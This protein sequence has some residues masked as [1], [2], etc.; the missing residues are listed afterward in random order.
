MSSRVTPLAVGVP[1]AV[2]TSGINS[3]SSSSHT[4]EAAPTT[5]ERLDHLHEHQLLSTMPGGL[6]RAMCLGCDTFPLRIVIVDN[7]GSMNTPDGQRIVQ[8]DPAGEWWGNHSS[9]RRLTCTRWQELGEEVVQMAQMATALRA[10]TDFYML[11]PTNGYDILSVCPSSYSLVNQGASAD[12]ETIRAAMRTSPCGT[13]P[14]T[15]SVARITAMIEPHARDLQARGERVAVII[16]TDGLPNDCNSFVSAMQALQRLPVWVIVR[17]C[18]DDDSIVDYWNEL[19]RNLESPLEVLDDL[20]SEAVEVERL[21]PWLNYGGPLHLCRLFGLPGKLFD[22]LDESSLLPFQIKE[23]IEDFLGI[24]IGHDPQ[25]DKD[26]FLKD[27]KE[28]LAKVPPVLHPITLQAKPWLDMNRLERA[29]RPAK[30]QQGC[31]L[32]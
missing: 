25:V 30:P 8:A 7:S 16:A 4:K 23:F 9:I 19:D 2:S 21:N 17:L 27:V 5:R 28:A 6:S 18:T 12:V 26:A 10:R 11:N 29:V 24:T 32:L 15:E 13:T 22:A 1:I 3:P 20:R 31:V 14:L